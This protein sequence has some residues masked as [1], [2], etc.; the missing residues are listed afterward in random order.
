MSSFLAYN[1]T[2]LPDCDKPFPSHLPLHPYPTLSLLTIKSYHPI[3]T[4]VTIPRHD[5]LAL[6]P[7]HLHA[8]HCPHI[9]SFCDAGCNQGSL[10]QP[11]APRVCRVNSH[12]VGSPLTVLFRFVGRYGTEYGKTGYDHYQHAYG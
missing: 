11:V 7:H 9:T 2:Y 10:L 4:P 8:D 1:I 3:P 5:R 12:L 6:F